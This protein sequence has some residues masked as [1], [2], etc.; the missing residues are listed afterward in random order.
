[1]KK[2]KRYQQ[3]IAEIVDSPNEESILTSW[4]W[5]YDYDD[6]LDNH[7]GDINDDPFGGTSGAKGNPVFGEIWEDELQ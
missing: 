6:P 5:G 7:T 4:S 2:K 1:M 3:P